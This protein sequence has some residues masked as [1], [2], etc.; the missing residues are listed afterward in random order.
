[1]VAALSLVSLSQMHNTLNEVG[2]AGRA[3]LLAARMNTNV[4][5][6]NALQA[7]LAADPSAAAL[8]ATPAKLKAE[9]DLFVNRETE[10]Q[11]IASDG[12]ALD[13]LKQVDDK[14]RRFLADAATVLVAAGN[15]ADRTALVAASRSTANDAAEL[16]EAVRAF[17]ARVET[18]SDA[19]LQTGEQIAAT[20]SLDMALLAG[21][22]LVFGIGLA[23]LVAIIGVVRPLAACV[24]GVETLAAGNL[25]VSMTETGRTDE[26]GDVARALEIL[27]SKLR[28][29]Q[30]L[31][32]E[33]ASIATAKLRH[34]QALATLVADF[35]GVSA[36]LLR[37]V[38]LASSQLRHTATAIES[39]IEE[40]ERSATAVAAGAADAANNVKTVAT[41]TG[42]LS[43]AITAISQ[44]LS[45][46]KTGADTAAMTAGTAAAFVRSLD[47]AAREI[48]DVVKLI[49][50]IAAQTNL[51]ALNATIEA[52]RAGDAGKG[53]AVVAGEV[54]LLASQTAKATET[55]T[56]QV[57]MVQ[58][59]SHEMVGAIDSVIT[60]VQK[61]GETITGV[62]GAIE[63]QNIAT[64]DIADNVEQASRGTSD[65]SSNIAA[66]QHVAARSAGAAIDMRQASDRLLGTAE[67]LRDHVESFL[68][69][70]RQIA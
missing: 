9:H 70:V 57:T 12:A 7:T 29:R 47:H 32:V 60:Q 40:T 49:D 17:F 3:A 30:A 8:A 15:A 56:S 62:C 54:K 5:A 28:H 52:A 6:M 45:D 43:T 19:A 41:A 63:R 51:L 65:V 39:G 55:I 59:R 58:D 22:T 53:F 16:R 10:I 25:D 42:Q 27:Q 21:F 48:G 14:E 13:L 50:A 46:S 44:Q 2:T 36:N 37:D 68:S 67:Q 38:D 69:G 11:R 1:M 33:Q 20:R 18:V 26:I 31:E 64:K 23:L 61:I 66:V 34:G 4:Q 35:E 24:R